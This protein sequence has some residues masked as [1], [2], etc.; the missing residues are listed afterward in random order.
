MAVWRVDLPLGVYGIVQFSPTCQFESK[1]V[2]T[3][4]G[5]F[6]SWQQSVGRFAPDNT[7]WDVLSMAHEHKVY[8]IDDSRTTQFNSEVREDKDQKNTKKPRNMASPNRIVVAAI[9]FG[10]AYSGYAFSFRHQY[11]KDPTDTSGR[12]WNQSNGS[13]KT[14]TCILLDSRRKFAAFG[15]EAEDKYAELA[16]DGEHKD[17]YY[18]KHFKMK[19][20]DEMVIVLLTTKT[21]EN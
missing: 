21:M 16:A 7:W 8:R 10:T 3:V 14:S 4:G 19:L 11:D 15:S 18:F 17:W 20:H 5:M 13:L 2:R 6:C 1:W 9:D 12:I